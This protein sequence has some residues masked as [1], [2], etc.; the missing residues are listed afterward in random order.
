VGA[1]GR[2]EAGE[3]KGVKKDEGRGWSERARERESERARER[4][5]FY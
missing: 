2:D 4:E 5:K 3:K 1:V